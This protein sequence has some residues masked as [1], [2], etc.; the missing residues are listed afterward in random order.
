MAQVRER[1]RIR[2]GNNI[3]LVRPASLGRW[4]KRRW[5]IEDVTAIAGRVTRPIA[6]RHVNGKLREPRAEVAFELVCSWQ[7]G[8]GKRASAIAHLFK[9]TK[10]EELMLAAIKYPGQQN[11]PA[12]GEAV[13]VLMIG[14]AL[15]VCG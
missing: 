6:L 13:L 3:V 14:I 7:F 15:P 11:G 1:L 2:V 12:R 5:I 9:R 10:E 4:V 8:R